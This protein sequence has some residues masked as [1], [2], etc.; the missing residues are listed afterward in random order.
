MFSLL[1][2]KQKYNKTGVHQSTRSK[3][4]GSNFLFRCTIT[5]QVK[6]ISNPKFSNPWTIFYGPWIN[7]AYS[8][9]NLK[10]EGKKK[11]Q[12]GPCYCHKSIKLNKRSLQEKNLKGLVQIASIVK[13]EITW[14]RKVSNSTFIKNLN[15]C[16]VSRGLF[17]F[18]VV[19]QDGWIIIKS[20]SLNKYKYRHRK[21]IM[22]LVDVFFFF[23]LFF[24]PSYWGWE[25][26]ERNRLR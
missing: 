15:T 10:K 19:L 21:N 26:W 13:P 20:K 5:L 1:N 25:E 14:Y 3:T 4:Y 12:L 2:F 16:R 9:A 24:S 17:K 8:I 18:Q 22:T 23:F 11:F 6:Q 7:I